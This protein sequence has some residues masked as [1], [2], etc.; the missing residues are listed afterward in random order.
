MGVQG[1][2]LLGSSDAWPLVS[3]V[4]WSRF[5]LGSWGETLAFGDASIVQE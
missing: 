3:Y 5:A 1:L 4:L 2:H